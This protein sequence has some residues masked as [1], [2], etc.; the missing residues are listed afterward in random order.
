[1]PSWSKLCTQWIL[2][3]WIKNM[4]QT[5]PIIFSSIFFDKTSFFDN[6]MATKAGCDGTSK[7][8]DNTTH[9]N[10]GGGNDVASSLSWWSRAILTPKDTTRFDDWPPHQDGILRIYCKGQNQLYHWKFLLFGLNNALIE[11]QEVMDQMLTWLPS[12]WCFHFLC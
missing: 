10:D 11:F 1:M 9:S 3:F 4:Q 12:I 8:F 5:R 2:L 6:K 7:R